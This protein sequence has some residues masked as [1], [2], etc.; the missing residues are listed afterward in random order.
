MSDFRTQLRELNDEQFSDV[1]HVVDAERSRR[2]PKKDWRDLSPEEFARQSE[3]LFRQA[4]RDKAEDN[5]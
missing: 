2:A 4:D 5:G 3:A 1:A